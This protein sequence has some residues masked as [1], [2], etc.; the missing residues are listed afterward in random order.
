MTTG[1]P[2]DVMSYDPTKSVVE[3]MGCGP[4]GRRKTDVYSTLVESLISKTQ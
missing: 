2:Q 3:I 1:S 4:F